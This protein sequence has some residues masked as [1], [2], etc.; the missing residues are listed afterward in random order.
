MLLAF[1][2]LG[3]IPL[4]LLQL[5]GDARLPQALALLALVGGDVQGRLQTGVSP[6]HL[7]HLS[8][9]TRRKGGLEARQALGTTMRLLLCPFNVK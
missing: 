4:L 1:L 2:L 9:Q 6:S 7:Q 8:G 3:L 5:L